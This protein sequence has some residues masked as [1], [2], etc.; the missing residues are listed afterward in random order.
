MS[1]AQRNLNFRWI[2][3]EQVWLLRI[4]NTLKVC[5]TLSLH[6]YSCVYP[7][8]SRGASTSSGLSFT[9]ALDGV[10]KQESSTRSA[11]IYIHT[12]LCYSIGVVWEESCLAL[13]VRDVTG[14][15]TKRPLTSRALPTPGCRWR[16]KGI[17][18]VHTCSAATRHHCVL[19]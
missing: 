2:L 13:C 12:L 7:G 15:N 3:V 5:L 10:I 8:Y 4:V 17:S 19:L 9:A 6:L 1:A 14:S 18:Y 16:V 11:H